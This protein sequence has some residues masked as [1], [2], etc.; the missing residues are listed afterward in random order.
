[1]CIRDRFRGASCPRRRG[2]CQAR[3]VRQPRASP[4]P[5]GRWLCPSPRRPRAPP[6]AVPAVQGS[7]G[8]LLFPLGGLS[9]LLLSR[10]RGEAL[11]IHL[12]CIARS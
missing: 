1:M 6:P 12:R 2:A 4:R 8:R 7:A 9:P 10:P 5:P 11:A 3:P